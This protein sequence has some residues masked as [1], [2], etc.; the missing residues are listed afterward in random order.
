MER[1]ASAR[2][3]ETVRWD[4]LTVGI[5]LAY[6]LLA[7]SVGYGAVL[8]ELRDDLHLSA[9]VAAFH[10]SLFGICLLLFAT[11]GRRLL[12][13]LP[14]GTIIASSVIA[15]L[16]GGLLFGTGSTPA[17]TLLGAAIAGAGSA[18]L[19]IV[20][21][22]VVFAHQPAASTQTMVVVN[23]F[24]MA[25]SMLL[26]LMVG[27]AVAAEITWRAAYIGPLVLISVAIVVT[28][29]RSSV[30]TTLPAEPISL[31][32][33]FR[34]PNFSRRWAVLACGV[35]VEIGAG[36]WAASILGKLGGAS[37]GL[38]A[39]LTIGFFLGMAAGRIALTRVLRRH[40]TERVLVC[41]FI[42]VLV[43]LVPFML[44]PGL[45]G[46]VVGLTLLGVALSA[47][48]PLSIARLFELHD[49]TA[50]LGRAAAIASGVGVT[51]GPLLLGTIA[52]LVG[53]GSATIVLPVFAVVGLLMI[54]RPTPA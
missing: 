32:S 10:G 25:S 22:A 48:Y 19:V 1:L 5:G 52:D 26:P 37:N 36:I 4:R 12:T 42:G 9:S 16:A 7:W 38:A 54:E 11:A 17:V 39:V 30:P 2:S 15:M 43:A 3:V 53:L 41:S 13:R 29:G 6:A 40:T 24:P 49:D 34:I 14:N 28:T 20:A 47:V 51:F 8:P 27:V 21:P 23:T 35:L 45:I 50:A 31:A 33:L 18:C 44:G 46:R